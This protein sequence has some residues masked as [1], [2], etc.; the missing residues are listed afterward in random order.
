MEAEFTVWVFL[1]VVVVDLT[2]HGQFPQS[3]PSISLLL[4]LETLVL[5]IMAQQSAQTRSMFGPFVCNQIHHRY[6]RPGYNSS[7][8]LPKLNLDNL[9]QLFASKSLGKEKQSFF[10]KI[11]LPITVS[12][13]TFQSHFPKYIFSFSVAPNN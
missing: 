1:L 12:T 10:V 2:F 3:Y 8:C 5:Y 4:S 9:F 11:Y 13:Q 6:L 7:G